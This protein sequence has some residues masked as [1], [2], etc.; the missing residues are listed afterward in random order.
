MT[1]TDATPRLP[2]EPTTLGRLLAAWVDVD[3]LV[4]WDLRA[5]FVD[6]VL[7]CDTIQRRKRQG[8]RG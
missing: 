5:A 1:T 7:A 8:K 4:R 6:V 3:P 2:S